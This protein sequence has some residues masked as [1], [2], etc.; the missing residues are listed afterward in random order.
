MDVKHF[1]PRTLFALSAFSAFAF[2][3]V[4]VEHVQA[5]QL[6]E[7]L[8]RAPVA[9][10]TTQGILLS[11]RSLP[12][13]P[14]NLTFDIYRND[15]LVAKD[16]ADVTNYLDPDG[17]AGNEYTVVSSA[18][19]RAT[20]KAWEDIY[21][22][23]DVR[24]PDPIRAVVGDQMAYY[25]PDDASVGDLDGD[26][27]YELV[28]KWVPN[29][30]RD[31]GKGGVSCPTIFQAYE[32][33]GTQLWSQN[34]NLGH[35]IRSG[36]HNIQFLVY[37]FDGDGRAEFLCRTAPGSTDGTGAYVS[38]AGDDDIQQ[39]DNSKTYVNKDGRVTDGE[40]FLTI[41]DGT[42]GKALST[43][44]FNPNRGLT[45][46]RDNM[47]GYPEA[48][49]DTYGNRAERF[50]ASVAYLDGL[51]HLP[52]AIIQRGYY[53]LCYLWVVDWDGTKLSTRWLHTSQKDRWTVCNAKGKV[54]NKGKGS[55]AYG[56]GVHGISVGDVDQDGK[57]EVCIGG[58][59]IDHNGAL[60]CSTG[61]GHGDA[62][63]LTDLCP[64]R[65]GL[66]VMM[67]HEAAPYGHDVHDATT[68]EVLCQIT[69]SE[70]NGRG[71]AADF[72]PANRGFEFW[73]LAT[74]DIYDCATGNVVF[75]QRPSINFRIYW[76]GDPFDQTFDG[77]MGRMGYYPNIQ[78][79]DTKHD[80]IVTVINFRPHGR[81]S[82]CNWTKATPCL[83]A[84][85]LGD[86]REELIMYQWETDYSAP[87]CKIMIFSTPEPTKFKVPC[88]MTDHVYRM[89][90]TWQ[91]SSYNQP[92]HLGYYLPDSLGIDGTTYQTNVDNHAIVPQGAASEEASDELF[93]NGQS[94]AGPNGRLGG[95]PSGSAGGRPS[96][97]PMGKPGFRPNGGPDGHS[98]GDR[99][100]GDRPPR[101]SNAQAPSAHD[102]AINWNMNPHDEVAN[103]EGNVIE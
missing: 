51:D 47:E 26:G 17:K 54:T 64:D 59:T 3:T 74:G 19:E 103:P 96:G 62:I 98:Q 25:R 23:F 50:N 83:Q 95:R 79:Y 46:G 11:W 24:R 27:D 53:T 12:T 15:A 37:D 55:S 82:C 85:I 91:N 42:T 97:R 70:D 7:R 40:E 6:T 30:A 5:Q 29:N 65:P 63:H 57:D 13:D 71:L 48:W 56:Q 39:T 36:A 89:G 90:I 4:D 8:N 81:P 78:A 80:S 31:S 73:S 45:T 33:D 75:H 67:P 44:W 88:L 18:G 22:G 43:V 69:S 99:P 66:E 41:F 14:T 49:G 76:T 32:L 2:L 77:R 60:L 87:T 34:I 21:T 61:F 28:L 1:I 10:T 94:G 35:N 52:S 86:W 16:I 93:L 100:R 20:V 72:I 92:P 38:Q 68:G 9:V 58:A 101:D 102:E 84:D